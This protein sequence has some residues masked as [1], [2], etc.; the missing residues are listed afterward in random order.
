[1]KKIRYILVSILCLILLAACFVMTYDSNRYSS[2]D[3]IALLGTVALR[4]A[5]SQEYIKVN[6]CYSEESQIWM[7]IEFQLSQRL[8]TSNFDSIFQ[9]SDVRGIVQNLSLRGLYNDLTNRK[10]LA[11]ISFPI[12]HFSTQYNLSY[13]GEI[14]PLIL[15]KVD[16]DDPLY[17]IKNF[18]EIGDISI[19]AFPEY[20]EQFSAQIHILI[21]NDS[22]P[23][24][25]YKLSKDA[26]QL[27]DYQGNSYELLCLN[28]DNTLTFNAEF[29][30]NLLL[31]IEKICTNQNAN[32]FVTIN[33]P[34][35]I[36]LKY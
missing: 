6:A 18:D 15:S 32:D 5:D 8:T 25:T 34:W 11:I 31:N 16:S 21:K 35:C 24:T 28:G 1:M 26:V 9:V 33:G 3:K 12:L 4:S 17:S 23:E 30:T 29:S 13:N 22:C 10:Q 19:A 36:A 2:T 20:D 7:S 27:I 14:L